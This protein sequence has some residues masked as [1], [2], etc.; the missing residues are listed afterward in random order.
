MIRGAA[1][2][3]RL[4]APAPRETV[5]ALDPALT[6]GRGAR[7]GFVEQEAENAATTG[8]IIGPDTSAYT[9]AAEASGRMAVMLTTAG[10]YVEFTLTREANAI[11]VRY[12]IP[13]SPTGGGIDAPIELTATRREG[14]VLAGGEARTLTL[15]SKYSWFYG[16][17]PFSNDPGV[18][19][20]PGPWKPEPDPVA[21]PFRPN[22]F[23]DELR[24]MLGH[25]YRAGDTIRLTVPEVTDAS[26]YV[27]DLMDFELVG[28]PTD[29]PHG[30]LSVIDFGADPTGAAESSDSFDAAIAAAKARHATV[31]IPTGTFQV[32]SHIIVDDVTIQGAGSWSTIIRGNCVA[33]ASPLRDGSTHTGVGFYGKYARDGGSA[34]VHM[35]GFAIE[36][37]VRER[38]DRDQVNGVGGALSDS[39]IDGLYIRHTKVG[40]WLDG[41]MNNLTVANLIVVDTMADGLNF[42]SGVT[43]SRVTNS[44]FRN[45]GDDGMAMWSRSANPHNP[46][47]VENSGNV[48][49]HNTIQTPV[50]ANCIAIYGGRDNQV[51]NNVVADPIREGSGLHA[52]QRFR[53]T[54]F[55]GHLAVTNNTTVRA[56]TFEMRW[57]FGLGAI[58]FYAQEGSMEAVIEVTGDHYLDNTHNAIMFVV[59]PPD[60]GR[61]SIVNVHFKDIK[62]DGTGTSVLSARVRGSATFQNV[63]ARNVGA[64][65]INTCGPFKSGDPSACFGVLDLGGNGGGWMDDSTR[66][67][68]V[69]NVPR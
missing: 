10:Q 2:C 58:W 8:E 12:S 54:P 46:L 19:P 18:E 20:D 41:P 28:P 63:V 67:D 11:T 30:S 43:N 7:V 69:A 61:Y 55:A 51:S 36:G 5:A 65:G 6:A 9:L 23:Y 17:Y 68:G 49:D 52:G 53:S 56:G 27:I 24:V 47:A 66:P 38:I 25:T 34:N 39:T 62:V 22:H 33:L 26:W 21:K 60:R 1:A 3:K 14:P 45:N 44:F 64:A 48:F 15:T 42:C 13:D 59:D 57:G 31:F 40:L 35:S 50:L 29:A 16:V 32:N 4:A 37:G